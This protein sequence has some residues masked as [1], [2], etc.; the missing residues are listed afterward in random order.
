VL[1]GH[2]EDLDLLTL[3][4]GETFQLYRPYGWVNVETGKIAGVTSNPNAINYIFPPAW[5]GW[6]VPTAVPEPAALVLL[7]LGLV[8][9]A[10]ARGRRSGTP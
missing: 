8:G 6:S 1:I 3:D 9:L 4:T 5:P 10:G 7:A 2:N